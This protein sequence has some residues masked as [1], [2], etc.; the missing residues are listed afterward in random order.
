MTV[1]ETFDEFIRS[2]LREG[3]SEKT[4]ESYKNL[5]YPLRSYLG[6]IFEMENLQQGMIDDF[7]DSLYDRKKL[8]RSHSGLLYPERKDF[9]AVVSA[10]HGICFMTLH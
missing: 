6:P 4:I 3:C 1:Q 5:T 9:P 2:R 10:G 8:A 7:I